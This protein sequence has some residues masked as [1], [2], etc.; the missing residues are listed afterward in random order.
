MAAMNRLR[1]TACAA[2]RFSAGRTAILLLARIAGESSRVEAHSSR[3]LDVRWPWQ[4]NVQPP[5]VEWDANSKHTSWKLV[6]SVLAS[7]CLPKQPKHPADL[8]TNPC[9]QTVRI[10]LTAEF[11]KPIVAPARLS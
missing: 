5:T 9:H 2:E 8:Q 7:A 4:Q 3:K 10:V 6:E 11:C 1:S